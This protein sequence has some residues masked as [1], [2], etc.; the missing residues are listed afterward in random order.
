M[1]GGL[2]A[3]PNPPAVGSLAT[4]GCRGVL[5]APLPA[6]GCARVYEVFSFFNPFSCMHLRAAR[7]SSFLVRP[8][9][10]SGSEW[11]PS[12]IHSGEKA[13][14]RQNQCTHKILEE[15][16]GTYITLKSFIRLCED[17]IFL[18][19]KYGFQ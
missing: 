10:T 8:L 2:T 17:I 11:E 18:E 12:K 6:P 13:L 19:M 9:S 15:K 5:R 3:L 1:G 14:G 4:L 7:G 16:F